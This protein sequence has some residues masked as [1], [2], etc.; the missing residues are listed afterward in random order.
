MGQRPLLVIVG[1]T[2]ASGKTTLTRR[3]ANALSLPLLCRDALTEWIVE[4]AGTESLAETER[5]ARGA[6]RVF[7]ALGAELLRAGAGGVMEHAFQRGTAEGQ[8]RPLLEHAQAVQITCQLPA[9]EAVRRYVAR[10]E[11]GERHAAHFD[12]ERIRRVQSGERQI[13]WSRFAPL[14]LPIPTLRVDT[15]DGYVP[16]F[17]DIV[18]FARSGGASVNTRR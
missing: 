1:G 5:L 17:D 13:D 9:D 10:F 14:D 8:V 11:R 6:V 7:H 4:G 2:P 3:L 18:A 12:A 15:T 16:P